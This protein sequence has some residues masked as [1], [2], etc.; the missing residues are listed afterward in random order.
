MHVI[1]HISSVFTVIATFASHILQENGKTV[2]IEFEGLK[3]VICIIENNI[4]EKEDL[5]QLFSTTT[6][7]TIPKSPMLF[8]SLQRFDTEWQ[9]FIDI[10]MN[11][12][13]NKDKLRIEIV[14][15]STLTCMQESSNPSKASTGNATASSSV[16]D[17]GTE[18][19]ISNLEKEKQ[20]LEFRLNLAVATVSSLKEPPKP[21]MHFGKNTAFTCSNCHYQGHRMSSCGQPPCRGFEECGNKGLNKEYR[22]Q[23]KQ[24]NNNNNNNNTLNQYF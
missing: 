19:L 13:R 9:E 5:L 21:R 16:I 8:I 14:K 1:V 18:Q 6:S 3:K 23:L 15:Q 11:E 20:G 7:L 17:I 4:K 24:V 2:L 12:I 22:D 10:E